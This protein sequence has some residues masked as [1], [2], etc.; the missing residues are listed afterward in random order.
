MMPR[1]AMWVTLLLSLLFVTPAAWAQEQ[2]VKV[3]YVGPSDL[4][5]ATLAHSAPHLTLV[6]DPAFAQVFVINAA[7]LTLEESQA[8][9][10]RVRSEQAGLVLF[11]SPFF[12]R[13]VGD[14]K[15]ALGVGAVELHVVDD[16]SREKVHPATEADPLLEAIAWASAPPVANRTVVANVNVFRPILLTEGEEPVVERMRGR[17]HNQVFI[18]APWF[19]DATNADWLV[20]PYFHYLIYRLTA[21]AGGAPHPLPFADYPLAPAPHAALRTWL[22]LGGIALFLGA[23]AI[24]SVMRRRAFIAPDLPPP[25]PPAPRWARVGFHRPMAGALLGIGG[26]LFLFLPLWLYV[27]WFVPRYIFPVSGTAVLWRRVVFGGGVIA[28]LL[29]GGLSRAAV[30]YFARL[31]PYRPREA[32]RYFQFL[33]W[34]QWLTGAALLGASAVAVGLLLPSTPGAYLSWP[35]LFLAALQFPGFLTLFRYLFR[36]MHRFDAEQMLMLAGAVTLPIFQGASAVLLRR[37]GMMQPRLGAEMG[38]IGGMA[39]GASM[40]LI[41]LFLLGLVLSYSIGLSPVLIF[42]P[43]FNRR[44]WKHLL[45]YG[46]RRLPGDL[47]LPVGV[48]LWMWGLPHWPELE[49]RQ[50]LVEAAF[51]L[52]ITTWALRESLFAD[53]M[54]TVAEVVAAGYRT[55]LRYLISRGLRVGLWMTFFLVAVGS[56]VAVPLVEGLFK[57]YFPEAVLFVLWSGLGIVL[58]WADAALE[59]VGRP[60]LASWLRLLEGTLAA[61]LL[62]WALPRYGLRGLGWSLVV[63]AVVRS[64]AALLLVRRVAV[65]PHLYLWQ[66]FIAPAGAGLVLYNLLRLLVDLLHPARIRET[67]V[68]AFVGWLALPLYLF[69]TAL[70]GG[71]E[72]RAFEELEAALTLLGPLRRP[73]VPLLVILRVGRR[74]SP[75]RGHYPVDWWALAEEEATAL[76]LHRPAWTGRTRA[77]GP[78]R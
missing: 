14:L 49:G 54:P 61:L 2:G 69:L 6:R 34:W 45:G 42:L 16:G 33:L 26:S 3:Y 21:E 47:L 62:I 1:R 59:G 55:L 64:F 5:Y 76:T 4:I 50:Q 23:V 43:T 27:V 10:E 53:L 60:G 67:A 17:E 38:A 13:G 28:L 20:W 51:L 73:F 15:A 35:I 24:Y 46:L 19:G 18:V 57:T 30:W 12:P 36:A 22:T 72:E 74:L 70:L 32:M 78:E 8:I 9:G 66:A 63:A 7:D 68:L 77:L 25:P 58:W 48:G 29:D 75:L 56:A 44:M 52:A 65:A 40:G 11:A 39:L 31:Y 71:W 41:F 37:W